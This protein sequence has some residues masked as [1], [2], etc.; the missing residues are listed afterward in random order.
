MFRRILSG[1]PFILTG[2]ITILTLQ[3]AVASEPAE[4]EWV[5]AGVAILTDGFIDHIVSGNYTFDIAIDRSTNSPDVFRLVNPYGESNPK[6]QEL[7]YYLADIPVDR[8]IVINASEPDN[9][10]IER[11]NIG[12][13]VDGE[14]LFVESYSNQEKCGTLNPAFGGVIPSMLR[15][16]LTDGV[17]TFKTPNSIILSY[18][19]FY[20]QDRVF[21]T[22]SDGNFSIVLPS[23]ICD[24]NHDD[25]YDSITCTSTEFIHETA[26]YYNL[27]GVRVNN[28][29]KGQA[30]VCISHEG[31]R[32]IIYN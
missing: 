21:P 7:S 5:N 2:I 3:N 8:Y 16:T 1:K 9:V 6:Y 30:V 31:S 25:G 29:R 15:G 20:N 22:N 18:P 24:D 12:L 4:D 10:L 19:T 14:E 28:P 17:I 11:S 27:Q 13:F 23:E 32:M 26:I